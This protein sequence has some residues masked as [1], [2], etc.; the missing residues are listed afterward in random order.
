MSGHSKWHQI[1]RKK[2]ATDT[3]RGRHFT[4]LAQR[5]KHAA[6]TGTDPHVNRALADAIQQAK[7]ADMPQENIDRLLRE[8]AGGGTPVRFEG[9]GPEGIAIVITGNTDNNNRTVAE[10]RTLLKKHGGTLGQPNSVLWKF[11]PGNDSYTPRF[12]QP[13]AAAARQKL[14]ALV[15]ELQTHPD[16]T[17]VCTDAAPPS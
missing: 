13:L 2:E 8:N 11:T 3:K 9:F 16:V 10:I 17:A 14:N 6:R 4:R 15:A 1:K 12:P 7:A 5:I